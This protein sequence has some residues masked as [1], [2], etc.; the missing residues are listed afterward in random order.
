MRKLVLL[1]A[2]MLSLTGCTNTLDQHVTEVGDSGSI[3][4]TDMRSQVKNQL[5]VAQTTFHNSDSS[6]VTGYYRCQFFDTNGMSLG[7]PQQWQPV[8]IYPNED[9]SINCLSTQLEAT[10]F[11]IEFSKDGTNVLVT[12]TA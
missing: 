8:T 1:A 10:N 2:A 12:K 7:N 5:L 11:K 9:Q 4:I 6:P 3:S